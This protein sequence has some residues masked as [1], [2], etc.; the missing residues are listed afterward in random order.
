[1]VCSDVGQIICKRDHGVEHPGSSWLFTLIHAM[2]EHMAKLGDDHL[3][4][5]QRRKEKEINAKHQKY[6]LI[7]VMHYQ[8]LTP[9]V[10]SYDSA[11]DHHEY[12]DK[13]NK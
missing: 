7:N 10:H 12:D 2:I 3:Y 11:H 4:Q 6:Q 9:K 1:M 13:K 5:T 8:L